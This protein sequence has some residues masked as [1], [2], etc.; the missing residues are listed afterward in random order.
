[1]KPKFD[2]KFH[3]VVYNLNQLFGKVEEVLAIIT[4]WILIAVCVVFISARFIFHVPTPWADELARYFLILLGWMG[5]AYA[6]SH[7]DHLS[8]DIIGG[9]V[10]KRAK[11]PEK[12]LAVLDRIAQI[13]SLIFLMIF[14][15]FYTV[16]CIKMYHSGTPSSTLPFD[17]WVPISLVLVGGILV[18]LHSV[19][20]VLLP[21]RYWHI[22]EPQKDDGNKE[23]RV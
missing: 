8:I 19:C 4:L 12:I 2:N 11:D 5:A 7:N 15:Y 3:E 9:I 21:K 6:S 13:L 23:E 18:L 14:L 16:F 22:Q 20:Y 10:E 1:M 17:M